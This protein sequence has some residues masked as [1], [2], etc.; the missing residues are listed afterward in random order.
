[1]T[2]HSIMAGRKTTL[3]WEVHSLNRALSQEKTNST[4]AILSDY[5]FI[6]LSFTMIMVV[7][8]CDVFLLLTPKISSTNTH[9]G[10]GREAEA[11][12]YSLEAQGSLKGADHNSPRRRD[13][14]N[15]TAMEVFR[16]WLNVGICRKVK[17]LQEISK[18]KFFRDF[19]KLSCHVKCNKS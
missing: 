10:R 7:Q 3:D 13:T 5:P 2:L 1:M 4:I 6:S 19:G 8:K 17:Q 12:L 16:S 15:L 14:W 18:V 9:K 11:T